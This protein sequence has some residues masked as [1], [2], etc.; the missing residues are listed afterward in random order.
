MEGFE[1]S[2]FEADDKRAYLGASLYETKWCQMV[3]IGR[4]QLSIRL[5]QP[6]DT[7][8]AV[9]NEATM[10]EPSYQISMDTLSPDQIEELNEEP[11][12]MTNVM[13]AVLGYVSQDGRRICPF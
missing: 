8:Q 10:P 13:K 1:D 11:L 12:N 2:A 9:Q 7:K 3:Q 5:G 4:S 6:G